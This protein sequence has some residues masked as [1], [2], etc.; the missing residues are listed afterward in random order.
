MLAGVGLVVLREGT[1]GCPPGGPL[2][3]DCGPIQAV[4][5]ALAPLTA[6]VYVALL[7]AV[8][9]WSWRLSRRPNPDPTGGRDWYAVVA[10]VG[11]VIA[12]LLAF[13]ILAGLGWLG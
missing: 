1:L 8:L 5:L 4:V 10:L 3:F 7:S 11:L 6:V 13:S 12:P 2:A 9:A